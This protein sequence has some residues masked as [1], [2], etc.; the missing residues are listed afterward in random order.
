MC[1]LL[2]ELFTIEV[3][4]EVDEEKQTRALKRLIKR[5][6][7]LVLAAEHEE[8]VV[9]MCSVQTLISTARGGDVGLLED[10]VVTS[11]H[12]GLGIG[13]LLLERACTWSGQRGLSRLQLLADWANQPALD[14]YKKQG[15]LFTGFIAL[16]K[17]PVGETERV[18]RNHDERS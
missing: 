11:S 12:R 18:G 8:K 15:W 9:G 2:R 17:E 3:G 7:A 10:L 1:N 16:R 14:F 4:F 13:T 5:E 6:D